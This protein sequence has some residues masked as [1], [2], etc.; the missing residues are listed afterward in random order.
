MVEKKSKKITTRVTEIVDRKTG[1]IL[2]DEGTTVSFERE[3]DYVKLYLNDISRLMNL[4][5]SG[6][7]TFFALLRKMNFDCEIILTTSVRKEMVEGLVMP[8]NTFKHSIMDLVDAGI[9][10]RKAN[11][12]Y[13]VNPK[14]IAR[15]SWADIRKIVLTI[16]YSEDGRMIQTE[17]QGQGQPRIPFPEDNASNVI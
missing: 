14:L 1:E 2:Y 13:L 12:H 9:L 3:P 6:H 16:S 7:R 15:G 11:N 8:N 4:T 5:V 17:F 10:F